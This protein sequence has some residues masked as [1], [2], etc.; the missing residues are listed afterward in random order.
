[1]KHFVVLPLVAAVFSAAGALGYAQLFD[2]HPQQALPFRMCA[3]RLHLDLRELR[4]APTL[5]VG[6]VKGYPEANL[7][8]F[9]LP[10]DPSGVVGSCYL[11]QEGEKFQV[12]FSGV[13]S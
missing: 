5:F 11:R 13:D 8:I 9:L 12:V 3:D 6:P 4:A 2:T 7:A 1:M 10:E